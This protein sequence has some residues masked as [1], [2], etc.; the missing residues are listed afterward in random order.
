MVKRYKKIKFFNISSLQI[1][2]IKSKF[3]LIICGAFLY[4]LDRKQIFKQFDLILNALSENGFLI[5]KDFDPLF[6]HSNSN[7]HNR[8]LKSFKSNY[9][10]FLI[11]SGLFELNI[12]ISTR[13]AKKIKK[14]LNLHQFR[15]LFTKKLILSILI[16]R[17]CK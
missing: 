3:D 14:D 10:N 15:C 4:Q 16:Q 5:I 1:D 8:K 17:I 2:K 11:E 7:M 13:C 9:D 12:N 6:K